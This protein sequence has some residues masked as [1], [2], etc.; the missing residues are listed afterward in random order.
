MS[1]FTSAASNNLS[2]GAALSSP[3]GSR[4]RAP[5]K[6]ARDLW[7]RQRGQGNVSRW[8]LAVGCHWFLR[9]N[10]AIVIIEGGTDF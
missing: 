6:D 7:A 5:R 2:A 4:P 10:P 9:A 3:L 8:F 1:S